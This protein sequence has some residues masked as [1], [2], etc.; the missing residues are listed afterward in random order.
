LG[1]S[2]GWGAHWHCSIIVQ[3][4]TT[5]VRTLEVH[6]KCVRMGID[7]PLMEFLTLSLVVATPVMELLVVG[8]QN[9]VEVDRDALVR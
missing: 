6:D 7:K 4:L 2:E 8:T 1:S 9:L 5:T 3:V